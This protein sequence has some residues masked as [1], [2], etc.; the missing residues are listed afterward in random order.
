MN[1]FR[2]AYIG[3]GSIAKNTARSITRGG[4]E[5]TAVFSRSFE[6]AKAF[7]SCMEALI[8]ADN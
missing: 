1:K 8:Y 7:A 5:I 4:H 2:W 6:K 3:C